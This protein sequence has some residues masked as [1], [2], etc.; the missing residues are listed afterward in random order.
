MR[1]QAEEIRGYDVTESRMI[2]FLNFPFENTLK[3]FPDFV[4]L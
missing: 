1:C 2:I 3:L 4:K